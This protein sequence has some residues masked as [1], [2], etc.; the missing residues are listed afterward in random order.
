MGDGFLDLMDEGGNT[1]QDIKI[2]EGETGDKLKRL[3]DE[4]KDISEYK[5]QHSVDPNPNPA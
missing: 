4:D 2:P 1:R 5:L 3:V